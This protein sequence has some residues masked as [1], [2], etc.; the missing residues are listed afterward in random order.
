LAVAEDEDEGS[1]IDG[2][3]KQELP[4]RVR[5]LWRRK[6]IWLGIFV[7]CFLGWAW[8]DSQSVTTVV[9]WKGT[10]RGVQA[11]R[12]D[13]SSFLIVGPPSQMTFYPI[14][15]RSWGYA[16]AKFG[17]KMVRTIIGTPRGNSKVWEVRDA[18]VCLF[19]LAGWGGWL[20]WGRWR[21]KSEARLRLGGP[22]GGK[23]LGL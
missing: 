2:G 11:I 17:P 16:R 15:K 7:A 3:M 8:W 23:T 19:F 21:E 12:V 4:M 13:G 10:Q 22:S 14:G 5:P 9:T 1:N 20:A 6:S 18:V